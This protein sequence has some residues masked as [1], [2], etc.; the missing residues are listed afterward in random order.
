M[1][2]VNYIRGHGKLCGIGAVNESAGRE[3]EEIKIPLNITSRSHG[4]GSNSAG[5]HAVVMLLMGLNIFTVL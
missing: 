5:H 2:P 3:A 4:K 1:D